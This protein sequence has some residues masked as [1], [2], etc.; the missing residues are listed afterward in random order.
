M[1]EREKKDA[2]YKE[3]LESAISADDNENE[4][5]FLIKSLT[6]EKLDRYRFKL[7]KAFEELND[8]V[9]WLNNSDWTCDDVYN[10]ALLMEQAER[11]RE[12]FTSELYQYQRVI[13]CYAKWDEKLEKSFETINK[14]RDKILQNIVERSE[15]VVA[16][17]ERKEVVIA[18]SRPH[19]ACKRWCY[20]KYDGG[21]GAMNWASVV[22][23]AEAVKY[24]LSR[25]N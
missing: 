4:L 16:Q 25:N 21:S 3:R 18:V 23:R 12:R 24:E 15:T 13:E 19:S 22:R 10:L 2:H 17:K 7:D 5:K 1:G 20:C 14:H 8:G 6:I 11:R 9:G